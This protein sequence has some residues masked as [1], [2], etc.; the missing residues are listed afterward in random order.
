MDLRN[1]LEDGE[2]ALAALSALL[3]AAGLVL[4]VAAYA[5]VFLSLQS[6]NS[7]VSQQIDAASLAASDAQAIAASAALSAQNASGAISSFSAAIA[8]FA[9]ATANTSASMSD[10]AKVAP[11]SLD[12]RFTSAA[13]G[14]GQAAEYFTEAAA[15]ANA[16]AGSAQDAAS[17]LQQESLDLQTAKTAVDSAK[18]GFT[19]AIGM[20]QLAALGGAL[21]IC[22]LFSSVLLLSLSVLLSHYP[23]LFGK[24]HEKRE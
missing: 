4:C 23:T 3:S 21:A 20:L 5:F 2:A 6:A 17:T 10:I 11:F 7:T 12:N 15:S 24:K 13:A 22:A 1:L 18:E 8:A 14:M 16:S 19:N 9:Q